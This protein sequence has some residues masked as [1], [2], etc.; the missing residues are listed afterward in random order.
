MADIQ[1]ELEKLQQTIKNRPPD[2]FKRERQGNWQ[3]PYRDNEVDCPVCLGY[4]W[5]RRDLPV[6][7]PEFGKLIPC[8]CAKHRLYSD[9]AGL[10]QH[11]CST[12]KWSDLIDFSASKQAVAA[13]QRAIKKG[14]GWVYMYG[15]PGVGK[16]TI[17]KTAVAEMIRGET[18]A[19][20]TNMS[21]ILDNLRDAYDTENPSKEAEKRLSRWSQIEILAIDEF[22]RV[23]ETEWASERQFRLMDM[24][25]Q[26]AMMQRSI[27]LMASNISPD[28]FDHYLAD[29]IHDGR[30]E[31][32][33]MTG[34]S[35]RPSLEWEDDVPF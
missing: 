14:Y 12:L 18:M 3:E 6:G 19:S 13:I 33:H 29:R 20:Y 10:S 16:T 32:I 17:L 22:D 11:D 26:L 35:M 5:L 30:F 15:E 34:E 28:T 2:S 1:K 7:H 8:D 25:Y 31:V 23:K 27:T 4:R 9:I 24:R 21:T